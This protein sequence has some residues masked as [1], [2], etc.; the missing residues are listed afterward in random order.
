MEQ[1]FFRVHLR[2]LSTICSHLSPKSRR[3]V[4]YTVAGVALFFTALLMYL[5]FA[6]ISPGFSHK[7]IANS[8]NYHNLMKN[9]IIQIKI[10]GSSGLP[11]RDAMINSMTI[12]NEDASRSSVLASYRYSNEKDFLTLSQRHLVRLNV[13]L[14]SVEINVDASPCFPVRWAIKNLVGFDAIMINFFEYAVAEFATLNERK[15]WALGHVQVVGSNQITDLVPPKWLQ[16]Q[17]KDYSLYNDLFYKVGCVICACGL[18]FTLSTFVCFTLRETQARMLRFTL[19]LQHHVQHDI[20]IFQLVF[21]HL[22]ESLVFVPIMIGILFFLFEFFVNKGLAFCVMSLVWIAECYSVMS[23]RT[24]ASILY[25]PNIFLLYFVLSMSYFF[26]FPFG[27]LYLTFFSTA[28]WVLHAMVFFSMRFEVIALESGVINAICPRETYT[29]STLHPTTASTNSNGAETFSNNDDDSAHPEE[30][31][32]SLTETIPTSSSVEDDGYFVGSTLSVDFDETEFTNQQNKQ[33]FH[34]PLEEIQAIEKQRWEKAEAN[35]KKM[36]EIQRL[37]TTSG[38]IDTIQSLGSTGEDKIATLS[39]DSK[40]SL[41]G[42]ISTCDLHAELSRQIQKQEM[43]AA[44]GIELPSPTSSS[45]TSQIGN[46]APNFPDQVGINE[47]Q[48]TTTTDVLP[49]VKRRTLI[50]FIA[51][52]FSWRPKEQIPNKESH[53]DVIHHNTTS[54]L[55]SQLTDSPLLSSSDLQPNLKTEGVRSSSASSEQLRI[56]PKEYSRIHKSR[57]ASSLNTLQQR[58]QQTFDKFMPEEGKLGL[59]ETIPYGLKAR[60]TLGNY[61]KREIQKMKEKSNDYNASRRDR[62]RSL[63][64]TANSSDSGDGELSRL[65]SWSNSAYEQLVVSTSGKSD[66]LEKIIETKENSVGDSDSQSTLGQLLQ[67]M[68][69]WRQLPTT[70]DDNNQ[71]HSNQGSLFLNNKSMSQEDFSVFGQD[72]YDED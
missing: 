54:N 56:T 63:S 27:F 19:M 61:S 10:V 15:I 62:G 3:L 5:H 6:Y 52:A 48:C 14:G 65:R 44:L 43:E 57:S 13:S 72:L 18:F 23:I 11:L 40:R 69:T 32:N 28:L 60:K 22:I 58:Q 53:I 20:P 41:S 2:C 70:N 51:N 9:D 35:R 64:S 21:T 8:I 39:T 71:H 67:L 68:S 4:E 17:N 55:T 59:A 47:N 33:A 16:P 50:N 66:R 30:N 36:M 49:T 42:A 34:T 37:L 12:W 26:C 7:C 1:V 45:K 24:K 29:T 46:S 38:S 31:S 25:F